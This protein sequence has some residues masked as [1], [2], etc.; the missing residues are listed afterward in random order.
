MKERGPVIRFV[1]TVII[2]IAIIHTP[3]HI[4]TFGTG[5]KNFGEHGFSGFSIGKTD[6]GE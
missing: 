4:A 5:I 3:F 6:V 2:L 1:F